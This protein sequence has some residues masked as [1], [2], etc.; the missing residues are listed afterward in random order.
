VVDGHQVRSDHE[1]FL[2]NLGPVGSGFNLKM[3]DLVLTSAGRRLIGYGAPII[4]FAVE[5]VHVGSDEKD[6]FLPGPLADWVAIEFRN[7][8]AD[9]SAAAPRVPRSSSL[10]SPPSPRWLCSRGR[11]RSRSC[12]RGRASSLPARVASARRSS[13]KVMG[14]PSRVVGCVET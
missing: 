12:G 2:D 5:R 6:G 7:N 11:T 9:T 13:G 1:G 8:S 4:A 10:H 14:L 3:A